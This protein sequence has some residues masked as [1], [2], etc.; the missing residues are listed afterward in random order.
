MPK[1][2]RYLVLRINCLVSGHSWRETSGSAGVYD[3]C[4]RCYSERAAREGAR[5]ATTG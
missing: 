1:A 4:S 2:M 3:R 5:S